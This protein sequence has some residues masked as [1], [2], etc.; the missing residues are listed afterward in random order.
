MFHTSLSTKLKIKKEKKRKMVLI[1]ALAILAAAFLHL[2]RQWRNQ[3]NKK[4]KLPPGPKGFPIIGHIHLLGKNPHQDFH[5]LSQ[6]HGEI[7]HM[8]LGSLPIV[9][10]SS[11]ATAELVLKTNDAVFSDRPHYLSITR[12]TYN[13]RDLIFAPYGPYW[14]N[15][16]KLCTFELLSGLKIEEFQPMRQAELGL[17]IDGLRRASERREAV[18]VTARVSGLVGDMNCLMVFGR[19]FV[20]RDLD[21]E[22]GFKDVIDATTRVAAQPNLGDYFPSL[23]ALD[24]QGLNRRVERLSATFNGFLDMIIDDHVEKKA[25]VERERRSRDLVDVMMAIMEAGG[26]GFDFDRR[27]VKAVLLVIDMLYL[28]KYVY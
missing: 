10:V 26:A 5:R 1:W 22:L 8:R 21:K 20:D 17:T 28:V 24:L 12:L 16:R 3:K 6:K 9:V 11:P 19:K 13:H 2:L 7:M 23:A 15:M 25:G 4:L 27:H 18:D 14:R